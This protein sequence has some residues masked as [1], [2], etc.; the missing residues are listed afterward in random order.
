MKRTKAE[1][2]K[3]IRALKASKDSYTTTIVRADPYTLVA[4]KMMEKVPHSEVFEG[5]NFGQIRAYCKKPIMTFFYNS[6]Q[7]P[8]NAFG[9]D[10]E[11]L[12]AFYATLNELFPGAMQVMEA[13]NEQWDNKALFH[14]WETPD[15]HIAHVKVM[16]SVHG[17]LSS[18][19]MDFAYTYNSNQP[20]EIGTSLCPNAIHSA[21]G[22]LVRYVVENAPFQAFAVHDD[23]KAHPNNMGELTKLLKEGVVNLMGTKFFDKILGRPLNIDY[24]AIKKG[25]KESE[26]IIC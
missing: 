22:Y 2:L 17:I 1:I 24:T 7:E 9:E 14:K 5:M 16:E 8:I 26:Y 15:G 19:G 6:R 3:E 11:E 13:I 21:D 12:N 4:K 20:S 10:T 25:I 18:G 23:F